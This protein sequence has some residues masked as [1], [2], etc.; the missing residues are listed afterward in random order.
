MSIE[1]EEAT[2]SAMEASADGQES[3]QALFDNLKALNHRLEEAGVKAFGE[4][5]ASSYRKGGDGEW[6]I[7]ALREDIQVCLAEIEMQVR[8]FFA[9][10]STPGCKDKPESQ[11]MLSFLMRRTARLQ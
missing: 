3:G 7:D 4:L 8:T 6:N 1:Q 11:Q 2:E 9:K 10:W 5:Q